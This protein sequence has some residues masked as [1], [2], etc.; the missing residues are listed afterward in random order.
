MTIGNL[1]IIADLAD[2]LRD[3]RLYIYMYRVNKKKVGLAAFWPILVF[4]FQPVATNIIENFT[5]YDFF[6]LF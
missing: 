6:L 5:I 2:I 3:H 4:F 1:Y